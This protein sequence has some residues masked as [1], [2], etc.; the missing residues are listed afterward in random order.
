MQGNQVLVFFFLLTFVVKT[1]LLFSP[2]QE[3]FNFILCLLF[4]HSEYTILPYP[5]HPMSTSFIIPYFCIPVVH[6]YLCSLYLLYQA[7]S[8]PGLAI[9]M[10]H[11]HIFPNLLQRRSWNNFKIGISIG[12]LGWKITPLL[13]HLV[14]YNVIIRSVLRGNI[15]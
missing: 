4:L 7:H 14:W 8:A 5:S 2:G 13:T 6:L 10:I 11:G 1:I 12:K 3:L 15:Q 9:F